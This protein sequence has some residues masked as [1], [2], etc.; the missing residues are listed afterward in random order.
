VDHCQANAG[1]GREYEL[2]ALHLLVSNLGFGHLRPQVISG[3]RL[4]R[5]RRAERSTDIVKS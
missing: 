2:T 5:P 3:D 1:G 4:N